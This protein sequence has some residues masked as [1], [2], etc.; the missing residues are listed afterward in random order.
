MT[1]RNRDAQEMR[2]GL[3][4]MAWIEHLT[5]QSTVAI[6]LDL[7]CY[8]NKLALRGTARDYWAGR[9]RATVDWQDP[10]D[11]DRPRVVVAQTEPGLAVADINTGELSTSFPPDEAV[12]SLLNGL[13]SWLSFEDAAALDPIERAAVFHHEFVRIHPFRDGNGHTARALM[14]LLLRRDGFE[15][16]VL[17]LQRLLDEDRKGYIEALSEAEAGDL[18]AWVVYL[19]QAVRLALIET[20]RLK[21]YHASACQRYHSSEPWSGAPAS[22]QSR[23]RFRLPPTVLGRCPTRHRHWLGQ[24]PDQNFL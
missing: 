5:A 13:L 22:D 4:V 19:A 24:G 7:V 16:E 12:G 15:Y 3:E 2:S 21:L 20:Q 14:T 1:S 9:I 11:W 18:T 10:G 6:D 8:F 17:I 23:S